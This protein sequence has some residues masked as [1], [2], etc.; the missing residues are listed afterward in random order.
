MQSQFQAHDATVLVTGADGFIGS[1]LTEVLVLKGY[2]VKALVHYNSFNSWGWLDSVD[3]EI[4]DS[5]EVI[6]GDIRDSYSVNRAFSNC[7]AAIH[8]AALIA[9]PYS[10]QAPESYID[11][12]VKGT[13]NVLEAAKTQNLKRLIHISTS[14]VYGT[15]VRVPINE[16]HPLQGQSPYSASKIAADQLAFSYFSSFDLPVVT[17]RPFNT[18]GPRQSARAV[19]PTIISQIL[20]GRPSLQIGSLTPTRDFSFVDDTVSGIV[21]ALEGDGGH[22]EVFNLGSNFEVSIGKTLSL[23]KQI[24]SSNIE[25]KPNDLRMRPSKSEVERLWSDNSK[26]RNEFSWEPKFTDELGFRSGLEKT[27]EWFTKPE[28][29]AKYKSGIYNV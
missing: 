3:K 8:L 11:T 26:A 23:L 18:Y 10:Y 16:E 2:R 29:L 13:L 25:V 21:A 19:I 14:E 5:I 28:N 24:M 17:V 9:I 22:G 20:G 12:N 7:D 15:A 6:Q 1:H 4:L 27:V